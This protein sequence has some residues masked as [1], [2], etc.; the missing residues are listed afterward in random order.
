MWLILA[1]SEYP[2]VQERAQQQ[3]KEVVGLDRVPTFND[4]PN[5]PYIDAIVREASIF[6][7]SI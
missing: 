1:L 6:P 2:E 3:L 7:S 5:L 4:R